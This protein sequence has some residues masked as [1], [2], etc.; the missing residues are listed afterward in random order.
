MQFLRNLSLIIL[1]AAFIT[2]CGQ[3]NSGKAPEEI[4]KKVDSLDNEVMQ[5]LKEST[6]DT[7]GQ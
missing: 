5:E 2:A 4:K 1:C 6:K 3:E 7:T